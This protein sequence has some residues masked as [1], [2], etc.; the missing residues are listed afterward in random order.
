[1]LRV[2]CESLAILQQD[3]SSFR[4]TS[5]LVS[6]ELVGYI[7]ALVN[8]PWSPTFQDNNLGIQSLDCIISEGLHDSFRQDRWLEALE[9]LPKNFSGLARKSFLGYHDL[10][11]GQNIFICIEN[12]LHCFKL[13]KKDRFFREGVVSIGGDSNINVDFRLSAILKRKRVLSNTIHDWIW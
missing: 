7:A 8:E 9:I 11:C 13:R 2:Y 1:M 10:L 12:C 6:S 5:Q 3:E 4:V